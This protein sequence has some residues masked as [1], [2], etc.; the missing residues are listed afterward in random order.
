MCAARRSL[1]RKE[2]SMTYFRAISFAL[3]G[4]VALAGCGSD[5]DSDE[6]AAETSTTA[7]D[8]GDVKSN[9]DDYEWFDFRPNVK[10]LILAGAAETEH[11]AILWYTVSDGA[12]GLHYHS[13]TESVYVIDG[14][15]TDAE[16]V[17]PTG[18]VYFNPPGSGHQISDSSGF[19][20][21]A[22]ASPPD[23]ANTDLIEEYTPV[24]IETDDPD[25][26]SSYEFE[27][28]KPGIETYAPSL[29]GE[30]GL[31]AEFIQI[32]S[33]DDYDYL[34][35]YLLVLKGTCE[36][37]GETYGEDML[38]VT[39]AVEPQPFKIAAPEASSCLAM[40]ISF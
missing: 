33:S 6:P 36:I 14:T 8:L 17:Y 9:P 13:K 5:D 23:F 40:G 26:T 12:V 30:G 25:L 39:K 3:C 27:E 4:L 24:V 34:G 35:N 1:A 21:L 15:Q 19:F 29:D 11:I 31:S 7:L 18:S 2:K 32:T 37:D 20:L 38:L 22:Y 10:K 16:G 28:A